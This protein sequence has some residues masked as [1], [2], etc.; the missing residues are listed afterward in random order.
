MKR[1]SNRF[2]DLLEQ[3]KVIL[4][5][6]I[7]IV[8]II[9][10]YTWVIMKQ[11]LEYMGPYTFSTLRFF[12]GAIALLVI[13]WLTKQQISLKTYWKELTLQGIFQ[14]TLTFIFVMTALQFVDAGKSSVLLYSMP[15]WSSIFAARLLHEKLTSIKLTGLTVGVL[16][17]LTI[18][19]W[20]V[21][22]TQDK[23]VLFGELLI[24]VGAVSMG[25][26]NVYFRLHLLHLPNV[27]TSAY[28]MLFGSIGLLLAS[29]VMETNEPIIF[30]ATSIIQI[31]FAGILSSALCFTVWFVILS[32]VDMLSATISTLL[33]PVFGLVFSAIVLN[34]VMTLNIIIGSLLIICGIIVTQLKRKV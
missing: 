7:L 5:L 13:V 30:N 22:I 28:Q 31:L 18:V 23:S 27:T 1:H 29:I 2:S 24:I 20:D 9:W 3:N 14:T 16:G 8:T 26:S 4:W 32:V 34:E 10:G 33:V 19:G 17:L 12:T 21:L 25:F 11:S 6:V 15:I